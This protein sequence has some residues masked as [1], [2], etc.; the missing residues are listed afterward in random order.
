MQTALRLVEETASKIRRMEIRGATAILRASLE[1]IREFAQRA[2]DEEL[3]AE[4]SRAIELLLNARP[5]EPAVRNALLYITYVFREHKENVSE[6]REAVIGAS[7]RFLQMLDDA[8]SKV[9]E[10]GW[11]R[12]PNGGV[13]MTHC[14]SKTVVNILIRA[15]RE[16]KRFVVITSETRP[17]YQ[18]RR[19]ARELA[20]AGIKVYHIVD[21][22][23]RWAARRFKPDLALIGADAITST[24]VV[25]NKIGSKLLALVA[26]EFDFPL[27]VATT[28]L[29]LDLRTVAGEYVPIEM[30]SPSEVWPDAPP[31]VEVL[32][33]AFETVSPEFI[34]GIICEA[35]VIPPHDVLRVFK[36]L[37]PE[38]WNVSSTSHHASL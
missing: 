19:T 4:F 16:G 20:E 36:E 10:Y 7:Q 8:L 17:L 23:M 32:N 26:R 11:R 38:I 33:P 30:R 9:V 15:H 31:N 5:T 24:G 2:S 22:A 29:K 28:L 3:R 25:I 35:G 34:D 18:G 14:H 37:Y 1:A 12:I 27:Y 13:I 21:A 6:A